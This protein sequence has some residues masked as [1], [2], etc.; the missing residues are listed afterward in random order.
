MAESKS[1]LTL[2]PG[3]PTHI[4]GYRVIGR[5]PHCEGE[6]QVWC[7]DATEG[8]ILEWKEPCEHHQ[9][10]LGYFLSKSEDDDAVPF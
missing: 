8:M 2:E 1:T 5:C 4:F 9:C 3:D 10:V 6:G 7:F